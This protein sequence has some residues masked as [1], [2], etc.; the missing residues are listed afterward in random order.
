M[1]NNFLNLLRDRLGDCLVRG[2]EKKINSSNSFFIYNNF[3]SC[4][5]QE[6]YLSQT[7]LPIIYQDILF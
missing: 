1:I 6:L 2:L 3:K 4:F 5:G 7:Y